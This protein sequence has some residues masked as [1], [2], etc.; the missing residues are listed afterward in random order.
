MVSF[1]A[2]SLFANVPLAFT[3][4]LILDRMYPACK[5]DC[6][7]RPETRRC[8]D[9]RHRAVTSDIQFIFDDKTFV[10]HNG[11]AMGA[12]LAPVIADIFMTHLKTSLM[13]HLEQIGVCE[14][15]RYVD[16]TFVL[17]IYLLLCLFFYRLRQKKLC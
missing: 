11:V 10:Q 17:F 15:H 7:H 12:P 1:D 6:H 9:C 14:W 13:G 16:D 3:I 8:N 4:D 5:T 2:K